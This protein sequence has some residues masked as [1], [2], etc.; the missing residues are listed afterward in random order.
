ML[1]NSGAFVAILLS[2]VALV[3]VQAATVTRQ[4]SEAFAAKV[5]RIQKQSAGGAAGLRTP[6]TE[7]ELNS[8]FA[9]QGQP[10]LP[11]G[12]MQPQ[13]TIVGGG[14]VMAQAIL[15]LDAIGSKRKPAGGSFD[16][17]SLLAGKVPVGVTGML[18]TGGGMG[19]L[20]V[21]S[22]EISGIPIPV[23]VLQELL[24][25][26]SRT[27]EKPD[28]VRLDSAFPLPAKIKQIEVGQGQ[29]VVVQ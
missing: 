18:Q 5:A 7:D 11:T 23:T 29:A 28:G 4:N 15:D 27:P 10:L 19:R 13:V 14:K 2:S 1:K 21:Q 20:D 24:T 26:Y 3:A 25:A 16:P 22:A 8:W 9:Y 12:L 17:F 6:V